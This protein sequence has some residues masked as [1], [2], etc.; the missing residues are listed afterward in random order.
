M[1]DTA[2]LPRTPPRRRLTAGD[3]LTVHDIAYIARLEQMID[4]YH[5]AHR[6]A[7]RLRAENTRLRTLIRT[8]HPQETA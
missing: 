8:T 5:A 1:T 3:T 4:Q 2:A 6:V 7:A